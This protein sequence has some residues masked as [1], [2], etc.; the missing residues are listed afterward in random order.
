MFTT[1]VNLNTN[2]QRDLERIHEDI[3]FI[4]KSYADSIA[5]TAFAMDSELLKIQLEGIKKIDNNLYVEVFEKIDDKEIILVSV[6]DKQEKADIEKTFPL[7][8]SDLFNNEYTFSYLRVGFTL[9]HIKAKLWETLWITIIT[10]LVKTLFSATFIFFIIQFV[11]IRYIKQITD[12]TY[13]ID[14]TNIRQRIFLKKRPKKNKD[15]IDLLVDSINFMLEKIELADDHNKELTRELEKRVSLRTLKL[16]KSNR[17]LEKKIQEI[18]SM[19][20]QMIQSEKMA[21]IGQLAA[22]IAHEI[23]NPTGFI[24]S[25]LNT[26]LE[27]QYDINKLI[28]Q[29]KNTLS[30]LIENSEKKSP[31]QKRGSDKDIAAMNL[32][33]LKEMEESMDLD[34]ILTDS[35]QLV[36]ESIGGANRIKKIVADM[37]DLMHPG[38]DNAVYLTDINKILHST[39]NIVNNELK[40]KI[41]LKK[42]FRKI[43]LIPCI[44]QQIG[45]VFINIIVNAAQ[46]IEESGIISIATWADDA[47]VHIKI[48]D[49]GMGIPQENIRKIFDPF[50]TS[51]A[52]GKGTGL[53]LHISYN[54]IKNHQGTITVKSK[55]GVG[56]QFTI[57]LPINSKIN[58]ANK[59]NQ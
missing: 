38:N 49:N 18:H 6:G 19:Q 25:N 33:A 54:M 42:N 40:Y 5:I 7:L 35:L 23:N 15:E 3:G 57:S 53:G 45:Q 9:K 28:G 10:N 11:A 29:Y 32:K 30:M 44:P 2:Y 16:K 36:K 59:E 17:L 48:T 46:A 55:V 58:G 12:F 34:Y 13:Q 31:E 8:H 39:L 52:V 37:K 51:K 21:G 41:T 26:M 22:G 24:S 47:F 27:Y 56:T 4:A 43:P 14:L 20:N 50:F 1:A